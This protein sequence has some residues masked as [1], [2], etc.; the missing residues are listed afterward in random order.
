MNQPNLPP[1]LQGLTRSEVLERRA[2]G[3]GNDAPLKTSRSYAQILRENIFTFINF[4]FVAIS[5]VFLFLGSFS[6]AILV[7]AVILSSV[8]I[9]AIQEVAAKRKLDEIAL[10]TR[11]KAT[12][13]REGREQ[14]IDPSEIVAG[15]VLVLR[16][17]DQILVDGELMAGEIAA[18]ESLLTG[19]SDPIEKETGSPVFSGTICLSGSGYYLAQK[20]GR[21][22]LAH[23]LTESAR[24]FRQMLTPLQSEVNLVIRIFMIIACFFW[25]LVAIGFIAK[26]ISFNETVQRSAVIAGLVPSGLYLT[27]TL[28]YALAAVRM[29]GKRVLIQQANA[30]ESLS[31]IDVLCVDKTGTL[32]ANRIQLT[33][34]WPIAPGQDLATLT[35][36][37][38]TY[39]AS[40]RSGNAT[41]EAIALGC[42]APGQEPLY[43]IPF[44]SARKWSAIAF[45]P[46]PIA[47]QT[48]GP[49]AGYYVLG[50]P[51]MVSVGL[52]EPLP[53]EWRDRA[54]TLARQGFRVLLFAVSP[55]IPPK[56][57]K[58]DS[59]PLPQDLQPLGLLVFSDE[60]RPSVTETLQGFAEA[61]IRLKIIS[62]DNP[63]TVRAIAARVGLGENLSAV[64]GADL[65][66]MTE[67]EFAQAAIEHQI[68]GR[69]VPEQKARLVTAL[70]RAGNYVAMIGDG[71][72]D[73]LSLKQANLGI[74]MESGSKATRSA[75]DI[76]LLGDSFET[77]PYTFLEGQR[78]GNGIRD[79]LK[80]FMVRVFC[81]TL[82]ILCT[83]Q[84]LGTFPLLNKHSA[85][86][87][88]VAVGLPT[89]G[90]PLWA[91]PGKPRQKSVLKSM[92]NFTLP[93]TLTLTPIAV[94]VYLGYLVTTIWNATQTGE[95]L[96]VL[97]DAL[98]AVPRSALVT[99]LVSCGLLLVPFLKPPAGPWVAAEPLCGDRRYSLLALGLLG[100]YAGLVALPGTREFFELALLQPVDYLLIGAIALSWCLLLRYI[101]R[102]GLFDRFLGFKLSDWN[103]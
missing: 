50:A 71:V 10:L 69:I 11:P 44:S 84:V 101:W 5:V 72:N 14:D 3:Q 43:E 56:P 86:V 6:D 77:L 17:G 47:P 15:D 35:Q 37:V 88:I 75:A 103:H 31:N 29:V 1:H 76:V 92:L 36:Q 80:L 68:F 22:S 41:S 79:V 83:G 58:R 62:G 96:V 30:V 40:T 24:T 97:N 51:E 63:D 87:T 48:A 49:V 25:A 99:L 98:L 26:A 7:A 89:F 52:A 82:L 53:P 39:A 102:S 95:E 90:F 27:V 66:A 18:D 81:V 46:D 59:A 32:T 54:Q 64:S 13:V 19:E 60:L 55:T 20:V 65:A 70:R 74:A 12:V 38:G 57:A 94:A 73:V 33:E 34:L 8:V 16:S 91:R 93:A 21:N 100:V 42:P 78:I 45:G 9:N 2:A 23:Q 61:G 28:S 4:V 67:A 85:V